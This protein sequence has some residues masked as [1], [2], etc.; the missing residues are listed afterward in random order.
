MGNS[1]FLG[2]CDN[3]DILHQTSVKHEL[4][5]NTAVQDGIREMFFSNP[6]IIIKQADHLPNEKADHG[7]SSK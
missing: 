4:S 2:T 7:Q 1:P 5:V 6:T 3:D